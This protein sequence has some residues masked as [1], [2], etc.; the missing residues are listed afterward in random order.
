MVGM[1]SRRGWVV[2]RVVG[3][4]VVGVKG[5]SSGRGLVGVC[6]GRGG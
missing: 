5:D 2:E 3:W 1:G 4:V 6:D